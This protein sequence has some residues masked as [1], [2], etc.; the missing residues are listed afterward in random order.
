MQNKNHF[1]KEI[2][3][4]QSLPLKEL[5]EEV[6]ATFTVKRN[7]EEPGIYAFLLYFR[8]N[9]RTQLFKTE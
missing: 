6:P 4:L 7:Y 1:P 3:P 9:T 5:E 8:A 2:N